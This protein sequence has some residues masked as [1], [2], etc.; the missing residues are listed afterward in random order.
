[1]LL[2]RS[3]A[4]LERLMESVDRILDWACGGLVAGRH[5]LDLSAV[6]RSAASTAAAES[7]TDRVHVNAPAHF[8]IVGNEARLMIAVTNLIRNAVRYSPDGT[9]VTVTLE[10]SGSTAS[11]RVDDA[12]PGVHDDERELIFAPLV[13]GRAGNRDDSGRGLGLFM[14]R[15]VVEELGGRIWVESNDPG[16]SFR[17]S[18]PLSGKGEGPSGS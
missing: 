3:G 17:I 16:A 13:R 7:A 1:M 15:Q 10:R 11:L 4:Q 14:A 6:T 8:M 12:G 18:I 2:Q 9:P 5:R